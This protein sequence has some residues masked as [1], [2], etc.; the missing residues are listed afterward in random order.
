MK[1]DLINLD[2]P[3]YRCNSSK[4]LVGAKQCTD[5]YIE[6]HLGCSLPWQKQNYYAH[7]TCN[8]TWQ[9]EKL[10]NLKQESAYMDDSEIFEN[11][12]CLSSC[13]KT[14]YILNPLSG[15]VTKNKY[16]P[17]R[18]KIKLFFSSGR[19]NE[20]TQYWI[21][22]MNNLIADIGGYLGL[23]LG[24]SLLSLY[25]RMVENIV[26]RFEDHHQNKSPKENSEDIEGRRG[27]NRELEDNWMKKSD[28]SRDTTGISVPSEGKW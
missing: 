17:N 26:S 24:Y 6:K 3:G 14:K 8:E 21:Y 9:Y 11:M 20:K 4:E 22:D 18:F 28:K 19:Y 5:M 1:T 23:L 2:Q 10:Y 27:G 15:L 13:K 7:P 25:N 16:S 12:G